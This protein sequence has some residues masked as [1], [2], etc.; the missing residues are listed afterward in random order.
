MYSTFPI[1]YPR[2]E[3]E[4]YAVAAIFALFWGG[5]LA[6]L[7]AREYNRHDLRCLLACAKYLSRRLRARWTGKG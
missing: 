3:Y 1:P 7:M 6:V 2:N 4:T 5:G